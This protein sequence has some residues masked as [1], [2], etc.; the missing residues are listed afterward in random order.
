MKKIAMA[1][2]VTAAVFA[3]LVAVGSVS[4]SD[5]ADKKMMM[6]ADE[7][8]ALMP[9]DLKWEEAPNSG[10][11]KIATVSGDFMKGA[12]SVFAKFPAGTKHPLHSH[13]A[14]L[15]VV[16]LSGTFTYAPEG[17]SEKQ[18]GPGSF[19]VVP[20]GSKHTSGSTADSECVVYQEGNGAFDMVMAEAPK[21]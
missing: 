4:A 6:K 13:T 15:K 16:V 11:V 7:A 5:K 8:V 10:G 12:H 21:K 17:Q 3:G 18:F 2:V 1:A 14:T 20:G 9:A 19:L